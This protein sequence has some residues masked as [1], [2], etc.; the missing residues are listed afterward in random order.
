[1]QL[2]PHVLPT[3]TTVLVSINTIHHHEAYW[4]QPDFFDP[5]RFHVVP[6]AGTYLPFGGGERMCIGNRFAMLEM[7]AVLA[8]VVRGY[9]VDVDPRVSPVPLNT[10]T[11]GFQ[12]GIPLKLA[13]R[14]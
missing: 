11:L 7:K 8:H 12:Q 9:V 4:P 10:I 2:G 13:R 14:P 5:E 1:M 6:Q 3:G